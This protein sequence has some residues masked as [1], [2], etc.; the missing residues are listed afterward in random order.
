MVSSKAGMCGAKIGIL[1]PISAAKLA[2]I[3]AVRSFHVWDRISP[4][5]VE[6]LSNKYVNR[7]YKD[8]NN[9]KTL[10]NQ[11]NAC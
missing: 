3:V 2:V 8:N 10:R 7:L 11:D 5:V 6:L 9:G 1:S 4:Q